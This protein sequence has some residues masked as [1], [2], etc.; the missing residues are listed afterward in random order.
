V[1]GYRYNGVIE[2]D[3]LTG[4]PLVVTPEGGR[5]AIDAHLLEILRSADGSS[6]AEILRRY[7][8]GPL[9][10]VQVRAALA[11]LAEAGLLAREGYVAEEASRAAGPAVHASVS[12]VIV[13]YDSQEWLA[14]CL[15]SVIDQTVK[16]TE[17]V[18]VD[19]A[20]PH[21]PT[22]WVKEHYPGVSLVRL[23]SM[24]GLAGA[25]NQGVAQTRGEY[26]LI[27]NPDVRLEA[28]VVEQMLSAADSDPGC[29]AVAPKLRF[30]WAPAFLNGIGNQPG[31]FRWGSDN[32]SGHLDLGQFDDWE[33]AP[34]ACFA[35]ALVRRSAWEEVGP[36]DEGFRFY[37]EDSD[38][39][40]RARLLGWR[41]RAAPSAVIYH[42]F[43]RRVHTGQDT[44]LTPAK[45]RN[46]V[47]GRL[48]FVCKM[49]TGIRLFQYLA[50]AMVHDAGR[51]L[52]LLLK[53]EWRGSLAMLLGWTDF[54][55][56]LPDLRTA[57]LGVQKSRVRS[58]AEVFSASMY[59][60]PPLVWRGLPRL[61]SK[62]IG[63][64]YLPAIQAGKTR[65]LPEFTSLGDAGE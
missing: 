14:E 11:C 60:P 65:A 38:W 54:I 34:S 46:V 30:W 59:I 58:D 37:Y 20:S 5:I 47:F 50:A 33:E 2:A 23:A 22:P 61:T 6:L 57:R 55:A 7:Q 29:A 9:S 24:Q 49:T 32:G 40:F 4:R 63:G 43:G 3:A 19:N 17:V 35:A 42:A 27:L 13:N 16:P 53:G 8:A 36:C 15:P 56:R 10:P 52:F 25:I 26:I 48:R 39:S 62:D 31:F 18:V 64:H 41:V 45:L 28:D 1:I 44:D 21:N 12:V 51:A